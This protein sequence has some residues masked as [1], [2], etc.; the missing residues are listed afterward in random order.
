MLTNSALSERVAAGPKQKKKMRNRGGGSEAV[1]LA[2]PSPYHP[3]T[4]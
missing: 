3:T 4:S 2:P 1:K